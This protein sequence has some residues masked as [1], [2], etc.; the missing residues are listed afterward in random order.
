MQ[1]HVVMVGVTLKKKCI[2][3]SILIEEALM[4]DCLVRFLL[5]TFIHTPSQTL[6]D[7]KGL[8]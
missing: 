5:S 1:E 2:Q 6:V 8:L 3:L 7:K 4:A